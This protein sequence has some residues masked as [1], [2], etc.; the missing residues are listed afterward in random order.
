MTLHSKSNF[1]LIACG[2][3]HPILYTA[4]FPLFP[5]FP[6][7][8]CYF[9]SVIVSAV[10]LY[11]TMLLSGLAFLMSGSFMAVVL[12]RRHTVYKALVLNAFFKHVA[13]PELCTMYYIP[14]QVW[15]CLFWSLFLKTNKNV[16]LIRNRTSV[17]PSTSTD[18]L[19]KFSL[20]SPIPQDTTLTSTP[21]L[22]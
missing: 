6:F 5:L 1:F 7:F 15:Q 11:C 14:A 2:R 21:L 4:D 17:R 20:L 8:L 9:G 12:L 19:P 16:F 13:Y 10:P 18:P 3:M 22:V